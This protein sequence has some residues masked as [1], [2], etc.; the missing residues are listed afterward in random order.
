VKESNR[1]AVPVVKGTVMGSV[2]KKKEARTIVE[3]GTALWLPAGKGQ[4]R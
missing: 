3:A 4:S 2:D 1:A